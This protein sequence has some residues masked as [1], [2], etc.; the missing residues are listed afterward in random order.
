M[1]II[2]NIIL[3]IQFYFLFMYFLLLDVSSKWDKH[4]WDKCA[5]EGFSTEIPNRDLKGGD[6]VMMQHDQE[7]RTR[8]GIIM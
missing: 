7:R 5:P 4:L 6:K 8:K 3:L 2:C 1:P